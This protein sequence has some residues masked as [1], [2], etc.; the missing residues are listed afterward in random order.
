MAKGGID[1]MVLTETRLLSHHKLLD[2][3]FL[4][5]FYLGRRFK[6]IWVADL[7]LF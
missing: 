6:F 3:F 1:I 5:V 7:N 2:I 4:K